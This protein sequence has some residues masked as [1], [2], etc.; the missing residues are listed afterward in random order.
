VI[1][2]TVGTP[3]GPRRKRCASTEKNN[4]DRGRLGSFTPA[5]AIQEGRTEKKKK[6]QAYGKTRTKLNLIGRTGSVGRDHVPKELLP[7]AQEN[8]KVRAKKEQR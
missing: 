7:S 2:K 5:R 4:Q 3:P 6:G 8:G 1:K